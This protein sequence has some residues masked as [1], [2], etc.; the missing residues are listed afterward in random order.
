MDWHG[1]KT[2]QGKVLYLLGEGRAGFNKRIIAWRAH[3]GVMESAGEGRAFSRNTINA[4]VPFD[5]D[6]AP[7]IRLRQKYNLIVIDTLNRWS[8]GDE[9]KAEAMALWLNRVAALARAC[10]NAAVLIVHHARKDGQIYRGSTALKAAM[11]AEFELALDGKLIKLLHNKSK[12]E[13]MLGETTLLKHAIGLGRKTDKYGQ[14]KEHG[15]LVLLRATTEDVQV[16]DDVGV[17]AIKSAIMKLQA[18]GKNTSKTAVAKK[19]GGYYKARLAKVEELERT[20]VLVLKGST[21]TVA[22]GHELF[23]SDDVD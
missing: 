2:Q 15:S 13:E 3:H 6:T 8:Q 21:Y 17:L 7:K 22:A 20:G 9:N 11:D 5:A 10:G 23:P 16:Q 19:A 14:T 1:R 4:V 18:E 12:D